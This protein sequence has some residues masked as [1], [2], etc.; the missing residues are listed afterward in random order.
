MA[1]IYPI[2]RACINR[3]KSQITQLD[4]DITTIDEQAN[5]EGFQQE[6]NTLLQFFKAPMGHKTRMREL[7]T[8]IVDD[9]LTLDAVV[10]EY[11]R[12]RG[13]NLLSLVPVDPSTIILRVTED[14]STPEPP[15]I[16]YEQVLQGQVVARFTTD[17][18]LYEIMNP[19]SDSPYGYAPLESLVVQVES[20]L[21]GSL[22][23][24][25]YFKE[26]NVPE[27]FVTLPNDVAGSKD[28]I[29]QW[30]DWFDAILAGDQKTVHR[31]KI[32]PE[33]SQYTPAKKPED[34]AFEKF[35]MWLLQQTCAVFD[36]QPQDI[37]ITLHTNRATAHSQQEIGKERGLI[38]LGNFIK[39]IFDDL[40]QN[41]FGFT[42]LQ[43]IWQNINP[44]DRK[45]EADI[46]QKEIQMGALSV[47]EYRIKQGREPIGLGPYIMTGQGPQ[48]V[49]DI[50]NGNQS[51]NGQRN[52]NNSNIDDN[53]QNEP[54][55]NPNTEP[56]DDGSQKMLKDI[57][58]W[59]KAIFND[60]ERKKPLRI[61]FPSDFIDEE[62]HILIEEG[63]KG[64]K[65]KHQAKILFDQFLDPELRASLRLIEYSNQLKQI[66]KNAN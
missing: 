51:Q 49:E 62:T 29:E 6:I 59:R 55:N 35:E 25:N 60:L 19:R 4:W 63:L 28:Q 2:A 65:N 14:G 24:L 16:A 31:L 43:F 50:L 57:R 9:I 22:Y 3:R 46:A 40:I 58:K 44:T 12:T 38:P 48:L 20:A 15:D 11:Q 30:Q 26:N 33:G 17:E 41:E 34:M 37:G 39:E 21:R 56:Q 61:A 53:T 54:D 36:V 18:L 66:V 32:L 42:Q 45:D 7:L 1:R 47:D 23:N 27:G 64:V 13:G 5:E 52:G 10:Y 8:L